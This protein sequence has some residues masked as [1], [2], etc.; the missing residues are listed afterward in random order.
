M[1]VATSISAP[2]LLTPIE[3]R[4]QVYLAHL[5]NTVK[6]QR[7][8][9]L[10]QVRCEYMYECNLFHLAE[11]MVFEYLKKTNRPYSVS[12]YRYFMRVRSV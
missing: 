9:I 12:K 2:Y 3:K 8:Q 1:L 4:T 11:S 10:K 6:C 5:Y 7:N